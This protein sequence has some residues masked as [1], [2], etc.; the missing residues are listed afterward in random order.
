MIKV[1]LLKH[2]RY[3]SPFP[4]THPLQILLRNNQKNPT[5]L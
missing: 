5:P 2:Q 3:I 1:P 4:L